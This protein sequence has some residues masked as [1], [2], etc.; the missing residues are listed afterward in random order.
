VS[1]LEQ[2]FDPRK[3]CRIHRS[4]LLN[5]SWVREVDAW[6]GGRMLVRLKDAKNT[7]LQVARDRAAT[8]K[9]QLGI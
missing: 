6:F 2:K 5:L 7:E 3:F 8:L 4:T 1:E 9:K